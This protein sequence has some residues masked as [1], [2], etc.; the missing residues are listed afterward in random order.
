VSPEWSAVPTEP[1][2]Q[3]GRGKT[4]PIGIIGGIVEQRSCQHGPPAIEP[5]D[6]STRT[7]AQNECQHTSADQQRQEGCNGTGGKVSSCFYKER[8]GGGGTELD[9]K[10]RHERALASGSTVL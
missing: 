3:R 1:S 4:H 6:A 5:H 2:Q 9:L 7:A 10:D 8:L